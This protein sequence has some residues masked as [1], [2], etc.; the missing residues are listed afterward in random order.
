MEGTRV[1]GGGCLCGESPLTAIREKCEALIAW[2]EFGQS[3]NWLN[4]HPTCL[5]ERTRRAHCNAM[6]KC[7]QNSQADTFC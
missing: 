1:R 4:Q 7:K 5:A 3:A 2:A 6:E